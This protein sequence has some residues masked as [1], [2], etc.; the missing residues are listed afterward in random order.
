M[1]LFQRNIDGK[2]RVI[3]GIGALALGIAAFLAWPHSRVAGVSLTVAAA[4][5]AFEAVRGWCVARACG[6]KTRF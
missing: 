1:P 4:F 6:V 5:V 2:G 3:R